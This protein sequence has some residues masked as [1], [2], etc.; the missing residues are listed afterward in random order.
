[1]AA[2]TDETGPRPL[3]A[4]TFAFYEDGSGGI[5]AV[6]ETPETGVVRRHIPR[7]MVKMATRLMSGGD[8]EAGTLLGGFS[9]LLSRK[10]K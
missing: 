3:I 5:V 9:G 1:M 10:S 4:G 2:S 6:A 7:A 8:S